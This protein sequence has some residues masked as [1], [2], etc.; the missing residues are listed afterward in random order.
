MFFYRFAIQ[1]T[2]WYTHYD[3]LFSPTVFAQSCAHAV[4]EW[5]DNGV[6][7]NMTTVQTDSTIKIYGGSYA[8]MRAIDPDLGINDG[9][10]GIATSFYEAVD[11]YRINGSSLNRKTGHEVYNARITVVYKEHVAQSAN[12]LA[13][14]KNVVTHEMGHTLGWYGHSSNSTD[15][16]Y[17]HS[18]Y[19]NTTVKERDKMHVKQVYNIMPY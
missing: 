3:N 9:G 18:N 5:T 15:L 16:M 7:V 2:A 11:E 14:Y 19:T 17:E 13:T 10:R 4:N 8:K 6:N 12:Y 1:P